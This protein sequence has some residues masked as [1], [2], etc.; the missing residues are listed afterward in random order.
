MTTRQSD[1]QSIHGGSFLLGV[2]AGGAIVSGLALYFSPRMAS[3]VREGI[4]TSATKVRGV[5]NGAFQTAANEAADVVDG[6][7]DA[8]DAIAS[9]GQAIRDG[10]ADVVEHGARSVSHGAREVERFARTSRTDHDE[11]LS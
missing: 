10:I 7:A 1:I 4:A 2:A 8:V 9:R 6:V 11:K 5:V 3:E